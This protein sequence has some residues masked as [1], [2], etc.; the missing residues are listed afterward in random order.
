M[1]VIAVANLKGGVGK[2]T[3][4]QNLAVCFLQKGR[5]IC[6]VDT[7]VVQESTVEWGIAREKR[8]YPKL[9]IFGISEEKLMSQILDLSDKYDLVL[10]DGTP[11]LGEITTKIMSVADLVL[12]PVMPSGNDFRA[13][14]KF[15]L[16]CEDVRTVK[17]KQG[18]ALEVAVVMNEYNDKLIVD[19]TILEA[20]KKMEIRMLDTSIA[21]RAAYREATLLGCGV[22]EMRDRKAAQEIET[23]AAEVIV[24]LA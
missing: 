14:R 12:I 23:L 17:Q 8:G 13:L 21:N 3:V 2:S 5:S 4:A 16:R 18:F 19:K 9:D 11:A 20:V 22:S 24:L 10:V 1:A 7:D 15:L 6:I